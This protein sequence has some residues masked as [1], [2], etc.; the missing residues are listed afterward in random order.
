MK[1]ITDI[2]RIPEEVRGY[3]RESEITREYHKISEDIR[4][5][6][7]V[8]EDAGGYHGISQDIKRISEFAL[9]KRAQS[10]LLA[11]IRNSY[12]DLIEKSTS[13]IPP[14]KAHGN[15]GHKCK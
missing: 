14:E 10:S 11:D 7:R 3:H 2:C 8:S 12:H 5:C 4:E 6:Q 15:V 13:K 9:A 1:C